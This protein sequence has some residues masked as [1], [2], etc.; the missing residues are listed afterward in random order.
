MRPSSTRQ[1]LAVVPPMSKEITLS[2]SGKLAE[3]R[4]RKAPAGGSG[5]EQ[6]DRK[7]ARGRRRD[8]TAGRMHQAK[9][10][11][12]AAAD[13]LALEVLEIAVHQGLHVGVRA[14]R[15]RARV[16]A[17][18]RHHIGRKRNEQVREFAFDQCAYGLLVCRIGIGV[19][20]ADRDGLDAVIDELAHS[21]AHFAGIERRDNAPVAVQPFA[22]FEPVA[23]RNERVGKAQEQVVDVVALLGPHFEAVAEALR[24]EQA[25]F[26]AAPLDDRVGDERGAVDDF[27]NVREG[28]VG[29]GGEELRDLP[30]P[31]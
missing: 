29:L 26:R 14:S 17:Q 12:K 13:Q 3:Q 20:E 5:L 7:L 30:V 11:A 31:L 9:R 27:G 19:Q 4:G 15:Y 23:A 24:R 18:L 10:A 2:L 21:R 28:D 16:F 25:K 6:P 1:A 8:E 22:D